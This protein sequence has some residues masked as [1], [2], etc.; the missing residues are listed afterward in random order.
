MNFIFFLENEET[1]P[2]DFKFVEKVST[3]G[4]TTAISKPI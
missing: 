2:C 3:K 4:T 1:R